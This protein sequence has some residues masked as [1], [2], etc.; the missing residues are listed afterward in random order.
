MEQGHLT[1][2]SYVREIFKLDR[3]RRGRVPFLLETS[4]N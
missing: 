4:T 1:R 2:K 3:G